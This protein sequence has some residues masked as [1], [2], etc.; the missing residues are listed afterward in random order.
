M[1]SGAPL[2]EDLGGGP[3]YGRFLETMASS[4]HLEHDAMA[5]G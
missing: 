4:N 5:Q 2:Q 3:M 1:P